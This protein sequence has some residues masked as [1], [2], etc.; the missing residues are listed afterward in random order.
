MA[1]YRF[2]VR[3]PTLR[4]L[5]L[6]EQREVEYARH[7]EARA[8]AEALRICRRQERAQ[9]QREAVDAATGE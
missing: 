6:E 4:E 1:R 7:A 3:F 5:D 8:I 2:G 9:R